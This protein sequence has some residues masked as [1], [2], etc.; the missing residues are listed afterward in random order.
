MVG[1]DK[2]QLSDKVICCILGGMPPRGEGDHT[3]PSVAKA[4]NVR[5]STTASLTS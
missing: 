4:M 3:P 2:G 5:G 1:N